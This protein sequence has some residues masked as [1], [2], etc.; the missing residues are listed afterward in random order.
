MQAVMS[1]VQRVGPYLV[2]ALV[3]PGGIFIALGAYLYRRL[4]PR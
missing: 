2:V 4:G 1:A 3:M